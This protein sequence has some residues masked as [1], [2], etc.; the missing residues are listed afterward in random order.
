MVDR[1]LSLQK[2]SEVKYYAGAMYESQVSQN[3]TFTA[4]EFSNAVNLSK[5]VVMKKSDGTEL[6]ATI[7]LNVVTITSAVTNA[8]VQIYVFGALATT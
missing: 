8:D 5:A 4:S 2:L 6:T 1:T 3:D 7:A